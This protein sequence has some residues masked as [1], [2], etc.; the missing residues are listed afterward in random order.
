MKNRY[1]FIS[2]GLLM[3]LIFGGNFLIRFIRDEDFY[4]AEF[5]GSMLGVVILL[6]G[7]FSKK[8]NSTIKV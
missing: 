4:I 1:W 3:M 8:E 6:T 2:F 5:T 7:I